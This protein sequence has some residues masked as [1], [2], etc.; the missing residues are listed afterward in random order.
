MR[1]KSLFA[2]G[3]ILFLLVIGFVMQH[4]STIKA[5]S[6]PNELSNNSENIT[7]TFFS[8]DFTY[9]LEKW[10]VQLNSGG[11]S[12]ETISS[13]LSVQSSSA[14]SLRLVSVSHLLDWNAL[15]DADLYSTTFSLNA[16]ASV[17]FT[18]C[19]DS[20]G[21]LGFVRYYLSDNDIWS[22]TSTQKNI[23]VAS[24]IDSFV[25][26]SDHVITN[27]RDLSYCLDNY[28]PGIDQG[29]ID[30]CYV[31][32]YAY[33][34]GTSHQARFDNIKVFSITETDLLVTDFSYFQ[35]ETNSSYIQSSQSSSG[36]DF[37][38]DNETT[39]QNNNETYN[40]QLGLLGNCSDFYVSVDVYYN[41]TSDESIGSF[42]LLLSSIYDFEGNLNPNSTIG[43]HS[44]EDSLTNSSGQYSAIGY[45]YG[46]ADEYN[47]SM[48][49]AGITGNITI[50]INRT[51]DFLS[52][53]L[54]NLSDNSN[55]LYW[56]SSNYGINQTLSFVKLYCNTGGINSTLSVNMSN[57]YGYFEF[58]YETYPLQNDANL[59]RD[60]GSNFADALTISTGV[61][62]GTLPIG[63]SFDYYKFYSTSN[64]DITIT[65][66]GSTGTDFDLS[67]F[68]AAYNFIA[69]SGN[70]GST[71]QL[72]YGP[73]TYGYYFVR[74]SKAAGDGDY[75]FSISLADS[76]GPPPS[77]QNDGDS[78][79]DAG[80]SLSTAVHIYGG[81]FTGSLPLGDPRDYYSINTNNVDTI[82]ITVTHELNIS[83]EIFLV[84][85]ADVL[86][87][88]DDDSSTTTTELSYKIIQSLGEVYLEISKLSGN[89]NYNIEV[90]I[91]TIQTSS[92]N[93]VIY[94]V[95]GLA[96]ASL[97]IFVSMRQKKKRRSRQPL[98]RNSQT[99]SVIGS[100]ISQSTEGEDL[101]ES[102]QDEVIEDFSDATGHE[103]DILET[104]YSGYSFG[105]EGSTENNEAKKEE[106]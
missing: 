59:G 12:T 81:T 85:Y 40:F 86:L 92:N 50:V 75:I 13:Y 93:W 76:T 54:Y 47:T 4:S 78:G 83:L 91:Y 8:E 9:G 44:V 35:L 43:R 96:I 67:L 82:T 89:G 16:L 34:D 60:A 84:D 56:H 64:R 19:S 69:M 79:R 24:F 58:D 104:I 42:G 100:A 30:Y 10:S 5:Q 57:F 87:A 31:N 51:G 71:E 2:V 95:I 25:T 17:Y 7:T 48:G 39:K 88:F 36:L 72:V 22:D 11:Y 65:L 74:I 80:N 94:L 15:I 21:D 46:I 105:L 68:D 38:Y 37:Y 55:L 14:G 28:L 32:I 33:T 106:E 98:P 3:I 18:F 63:D 90:E 101:I 49:S 41:Y 53:H 6:L 26:I 73:T 99:L 27:N 29:E 1:K 23:R 20:S 45:P 102:P 62:S 61:Y 66:S 97:L 103:K 70:S 52:L 77:T